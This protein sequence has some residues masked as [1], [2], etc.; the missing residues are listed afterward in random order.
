MRSIQSQARVPAIDNSYHGAQ[1]AMTEQSSLIGLTKSARK[2]QS[3]LANS[4]ASVQDVWSKQHPNQTSYVP[5]K[6]NSL[7]RANLNQSY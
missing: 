6:S 3:P 7:L 4:Y 2:D 1:N 5:R